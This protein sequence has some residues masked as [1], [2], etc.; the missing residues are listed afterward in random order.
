MEKVKSRSDFKSMLSYFE[1]MAKYLLKKKSTWLSPLIFGLFFIAI[2]AIIGNISGQ[3]QATKLR[4]F[5]SITGLFSIVFFSIFG[6]I[7]GINLFRDPS[8]EGIELLVVSKPLE[9]WHIIMVKFLLF[10][11]VGFVFFI[12]NIILFAICAV[13]LGVG[14]GGAFT[15]IA[16]GIPL[17][18]WFSYLLFGTLSILISIKFNSKTILGVGMVIVMGLSVADTFFGNFSSVFIKNQTDDFKEKQGLDDFSPTPFSHYIDDKGNHIPF[19]KGAG[20]ITGGVRGGAGGNLKI[21]SNRQIDLSTLVYLD[22]DQANNPTGIQNVWNKTE[23]SLWV[24]QMVLYLN[25]ISAF[26]KLGLLGNYPIQSETARSADEINENDYSWKADIVQNFSEWNDGNG[27]NWS[28]KGID[29]N[30]DDRP[31]LKEPNYKTFKIG[32]VN[33]LASFP[34]IPE[35]NKKQRNAFVDETEDSTTNWVQVIRDNKDKID[36]LIDTNLA[37]LTI[38][39]GNF[40]QI[41]PG[42]QPPAQTNPKKTKALENIKSAIKDTTNGFDAA[43]FDQ[44]KTLTYYDKDANKQNNWTT[45]EDAQ[46]DLLYYVSQLVA[47]NE[48]YFNKGK[49]ATQQ[50]NNDFRKEVEDSVEVVTPNRP[51]NQG[52]FG[53]QLDVG[54]Q[55]ITTQGL[56]RLVPAIRTQTWGLVLLWIAIIMAINAGTIFMYFKE[57][58]R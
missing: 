54:I 17:T 55:K 20:S 4:M 34:G 57:D 25:P 56:V 27:T 10:N 15:S 38:S 44:F 29:L 26:N 8:G 43:F 9:R 31:D 13:I 22:G 12:V 30:L 42:Q 39:Q 28:L 45:I 19:V 52:F 47:T 2:S 1:F 24:Y 51:T 23:E 21:N 7:K 58:F 50:A 46:V 53:E 41:P 37:T 3:T 40:Q 5:Q 6:M 32:K 48:Y 33:P 36:K 49:A 14:S 11:I 18:N 16:A 35:E